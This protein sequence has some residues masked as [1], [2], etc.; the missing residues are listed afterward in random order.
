MLKHLRKINHTYRKNYIVVVFILVVP[1]LFGHRYVKLGNAMSDLVLR[2]RMYYVPMGRMSYFVDLDRP[3]HFLPG[4]LFTSACNGGQRN[5]C[6]LRNVYNITNGRRNT[7]KDWRCWEKGHVHWQRSRFLC[8][9]ST[10][11]S[12]IAISFFNLVLCWFY[13]DVSR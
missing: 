4:M 3:V 9:W 12:S 6:Q 10:M 7:P 11:L 5:R 13:I 8:L 1:L 2:F